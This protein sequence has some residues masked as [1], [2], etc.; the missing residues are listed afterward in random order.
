MYLCVALL[1]SGDLSRSLKREPWGTLLEKINKFREILR[2]VT[3]IKLKFKGNKN[4]K[5]IKQQNNIA[6]TVGDL[7]KLRNLRKAGSEGA[8]KEE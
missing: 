5:N 7:N 1:W 3:V 6:L 8:E 2:N 4:S